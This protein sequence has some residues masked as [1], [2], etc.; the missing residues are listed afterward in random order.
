MQC[1]RQTFPSSLAL[2]A[3]AMTFSL[4]VC[5]QAQTVTNLAT[6]NGAN[7]SGPFA[8]VV[9]ATDGNF[10]GTTT[11]GARTDLQGMVFSTELRLPAR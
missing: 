4:A 3:L 11:E 2:M 5:A 1:K 8:S 6:F 7:G 9:Q 10:Y